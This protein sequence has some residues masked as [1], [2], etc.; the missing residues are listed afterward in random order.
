VEPPS[1][2]IGT[3]PARGKITTSSFSTAATS[4]SLSKTSPTS[5]RVTCFLHRGIG[6][7][8]VFHFPVRHRVGSDQKIATAWEKYI[9]LQFEILSRSDVSFNSIHDRAKRSETE[10]I[11]D[12]SWITDEL[13]A[14]QG[15]DI[16]HEPW[17]RA[18]WGAT[19]QG[20]ALR[21]WVSEHK[22]GPNRVVCRTPLTNIRITT[23]FAGEHEV[24]IIDPD[25]VE[26]VAAIGCSVKRER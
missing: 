21:S 13:A 11:H 10:H 22:F 2:S 24:R 14:Q 26:F 3:T 7:A 5:K 6:D 17:T 18:L 25:R 12:R 16:E 20:F 4:A 9:K 8:K 23:F 1:P 19:H 15:L